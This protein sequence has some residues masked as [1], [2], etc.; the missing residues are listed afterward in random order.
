MICPYCN[1][2]VENNFVTHIVSE[3]LD[4]GVCKGNIDGND[5]YFVYFRNEDDIDRFIETFYYYIR[6]YTYKAIRFVNPGWYFIHCLDD[7][8]DPRLFGNTVIDLITIAEHKIQLQ[9]E[10]LA[11]LRKFVD[12]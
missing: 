8:N 5:G 11:N 6:G 1:I 12:I 3:H 7:N 4:Y 10:N 9:E 2:E